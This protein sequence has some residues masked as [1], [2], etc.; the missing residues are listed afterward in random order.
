MIHTEFQCRIQEI[1]FKDI[2]F[3]ERGGQLRFKATPCLS[4]STAKQ[5]ALLPQYAEVTVEFGQKEARLKSMST[6]IFLSFVFDMTKI[7][8]V[9]QTTCKQLY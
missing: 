9:F 5:I 6:D 8:P 2:A 3:C 4:E 1:D 7:L